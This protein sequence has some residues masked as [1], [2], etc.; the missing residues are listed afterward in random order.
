MKNNKLTISLISIFCGFLIGSLILLVTGFNP[1]IIIQAM[2]T[3]TVSSPANLTN[4]V[5][6]SIVPLV[7]TGL[8]V[9]FAYKTG[10]FN[11][12]AEG[13]FQMG[14]ITS[15]AV[16]VS[17]PEMPFKTGALIALAAGVIAGA[18]WALL[19]A[20]LKA[21]LNIHEV[22]VTI[23][24][25][26]IAFFI[27]NYIIVTYLFGDYKTTSQ[28]I[29]A[30]NKLLVE[31]DVTGNIGS[32]ISM[33]IVILLCVLAVL[34]YWF[35]IEKT[36]L[37]YEIKAVGHSSDAAKYAGINA[38]ARVIQ[39]MLISGAFAGLAGAIFVLCIGQ[40]SVLA[41]FQGYGFNGI[42]VAMLGQLSG[43]GILASGVLIG[44]LTTSAGAMEI[45]MVPREIADIIIG[46]IILFSAVGPII[47][48]KILSRKKG[49]K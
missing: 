15:L 6:Y 45:Q 34:I 32:M 39:T 16:A 41:A 25:N 27:S 4:W 38:K 26:W 24:M 14:S 22:V 13:Q 46:L 31:T 3:V 33:S 40:L 47:S 10:L 21:Y 2:F 29:K 1:F 35:I 11:I 18:L 36:L 43:V 42:A 48:K 37:G 9:G 20:I 44:S 19:P 7:L 17:L 30:S 23:M 8:S 49:D 12:G 28:T 5:L